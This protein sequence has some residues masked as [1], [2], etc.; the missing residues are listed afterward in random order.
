MGGGP[1][2]W[3]WPERS[4]DGFV[5]EKALL[6]VVERSSAL[7]QHKAW[8]QA[9]GQAAP[10]K[11]SQPPRLQLR[12]PTVG[13]SLSGSSSRGAPAEVWARGCWKPSPSTHNGDACASMGGAGSQGCSTAFQAQRCSLGSMGENQRLPGGEEGLQVTQHHLPPSLPTAASS[14]VRGV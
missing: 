9:G 4:C 14:G 12:L 6:G 1:G 10:Q 5:S 2:L 11:W 8:G 3:R 7:V 13:M